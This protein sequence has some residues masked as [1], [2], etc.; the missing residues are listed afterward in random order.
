MKKE[1]VNIKQSQKGKE[2]DKRTDKKN[3]L[4]Y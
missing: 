4:D 3:C 1:L 2:K